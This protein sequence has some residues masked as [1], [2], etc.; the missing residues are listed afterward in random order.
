MEK[1]NK[2]LIFE[3]MGISSP[4]F[5]MQ[6]PVNDAYVPSSAPMSQI[7]NIL[8][9]EGYFP[10]FDNLGRVQ[11]MSTDEHP[12]EYEKFR[13]DFSDAWRKISLPY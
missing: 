3:R 10:M 13:K 1:T 8:D 6:Q 7:L 11:F 2:Q 4:K 12:Q 5:T 9:R